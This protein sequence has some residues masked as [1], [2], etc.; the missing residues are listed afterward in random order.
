MQYASK[1]YLFH[2]QGGCTTFLW[3]Q[4]PPLRP[5]MPKN[6]FKVQV[7]KLL[8][9]FCGCPKFS[10]RLNLPHHPISSIPK[11]ATP[12]FCYPRDTFL[13]LKMTK[14]APKLNAI[15]SITFEVWMESSCGCPKFLST[16]NMPFHPILSTCKEANPHIHDPR[17]PN[18]SPKIMK[19]KP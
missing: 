15:P 9:S 14:N 8:K 5:K 6:T 11:E 3:P 16:S 2:I 19:K 17:V 12:Q 7:I 4:W 1:S 18:Q 13:S 10:P